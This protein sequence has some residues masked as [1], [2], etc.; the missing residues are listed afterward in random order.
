MGDSPS[1]A[2]AIWPP[3][4]SLLKVP[5]RTLH[6]DFPQEVEKKCHPAAIPKALWHNV[7]VI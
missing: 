7:K 6:M 4:A 1:K 2:T 5:L 3:V